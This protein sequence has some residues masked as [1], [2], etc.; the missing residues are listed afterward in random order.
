MASMAARSS[1]FSYFFSQSLTEDSSQRRP[2]R[3]GSMMLGG[4]G[5]RRRMR[6]LMAARAELGRAVPRPRYRPSCSAS[7]KALL[8]AGEGRG[9]ER[10][11]LRVEGR[12]GDDRKVITSWITQAVSLRN[13]NLNRS[14]AAVRLPEDVTQRRASSVGFRTATVETD[15]PGSQRCS[16]SAQGG[17]QSRCA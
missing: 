4:I 5:C 16:K 1:D 8:P 2:D 10:S 15:L 11:E 7:S 3:P 9:T 12:M 17:P 14:V 6:M 13:G